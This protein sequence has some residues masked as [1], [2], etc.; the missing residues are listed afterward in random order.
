M[1]NNLMKLIV[2]VSILALALRVWV[3][4]TETQT[5]YENA[6]GYAENSIAILKRDNLKLRSSNVVKVSVITNQ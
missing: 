2:V 4:V 5:S 6:L 3:D 1:K